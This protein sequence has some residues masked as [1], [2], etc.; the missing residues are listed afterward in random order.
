MNNIIETPDRLYAKNLGISILIV[1]AAAAGLFA[2]PEIPPD[3]GEGAERMETQSSQSAQTP[4]IAIKEWP[5]YARSTARAM[6]EKY[7]EPNRFS[8]EA[9][10]WYNNAP[11]QK[12]VVY[13]EA[14]PHF[15][16]MRDKDYL[17]QTIAYQVP[18]EKVDALKRFDMRLD[19]DQ[20][21]GELSSRSESESMNF[22]ALNLADEIIN[23]RRSVEDARDFY[24][25][26]DE[27]SASG[28]SSPYLQ[29]FLFE[30]Q[31]DRSSSPEDA[32]SP[33]KL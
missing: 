4:E 23:D 9:L 19:V 7:G 31:N 10:V 14:W 24:Q 5:D 17:V 22:L 8:D 26:T 28:K 2:Q 30:L 1:A 25:E 15:A 20:T 13:R 21:A 11:W 29:G 16:G 6:I 32:K 3:E 27:L 12:T 18:S 33:E